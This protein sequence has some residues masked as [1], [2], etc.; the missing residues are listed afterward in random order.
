MP[1]PPVTKV[2]TML[3]RKLTINDALAAATSAETRF[4][5][6]LEEPSFDVG[7]YKPEGTDSQGSH[8]RDEL[9]VV[10]SGTGEADSICKCST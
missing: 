7:L 3:S 9:Y 1:G 6:L 10:A 8:T 5:R 4:A 2:G